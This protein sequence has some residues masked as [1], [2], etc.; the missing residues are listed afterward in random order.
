MRTTH[1]IVETRI[2][3]CGNKNWFCCNHF[4]FRS[5]Y[6]LRISQKTFNCRNWLFVKKKSLMIASAFLLSVYYY[7]KLRYVWECISQKFHDISSTSIS[8]F[9]KKQFTRFSEN[10]WE[11]LNC[12]QQMSLRLGKDRTSLSLIKHSC[13][14]ISL[15]TVPMIMALI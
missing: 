9:L 1:T 11:L 6:A 10:A 12:T 7:C 4:V 15:K 3:I 8:P 2:Q 5:F 14:S 13:I